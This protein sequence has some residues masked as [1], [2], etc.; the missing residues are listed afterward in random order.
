MN[1]QWFLLLRDEHFPGVAWAT[2]L[3]DEHFPGRDATA[4]LPGWERPTSLWGN[5]I[6]HV[7]LAN[8]ALR[9]RPLATIESDFDWGNILFV[10][11]AAPLQ[12]PNTLFA[13]S[14]ICS[15]CKQLY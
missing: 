14:E 2:I 3:G 7:V 6:A 11:Y 5:T 10:W 12:A 1:Y 9:A 8:T 15:T 13:T 4:Q